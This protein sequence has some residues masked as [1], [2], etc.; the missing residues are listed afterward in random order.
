MAYDPAPAR[1][2][3]EPGTRHERAGTVTGPTR[4]EPEHEVVLSN[5]Y[6]LQA[7]LRGDPAS[8][9]PARRPAHI[10]DARIIPISESPEPT[11]SDLATAAEARVASLQARLAQ[12]EGEFTSVV[13]RLWPGPIDPH[14]HAL[15]D[16]AVVQLQRAIDRRLQGS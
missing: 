6:D 15:P 12:L 3:T 1:N 2:R 9:V 14:Q 13:A 10:D 8:L 5:L 11:P 4:S 7:R 16:A